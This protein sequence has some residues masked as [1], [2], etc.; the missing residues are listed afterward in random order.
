MIIKIHQSLNT[1]RAFYYNEEKVEKKEAYFFAFANANCANPFMY[2]RS[3]RMN[4]LTQIEDGNTRAKHKCFH[5]SI[6]PAVSDLDR[7]DSSSLKTE[8]HSLMD[9][10]GYGQQPYYVYRHQ[11]I[12]R[13]HYHVVSTRI[14][15]NTR[16]QIKNSND[17]YIIKDFIK[18]LNLKY[19]LETSQGKKAAVNLIASFKSTDLKASIQQV[20]GLLNQI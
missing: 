20:F 4:I 9:K 3:F 13:E 14:D 19:K 1:G 15:V 2:E 6:N 12:K 10:L 8:I 11:D 16:K 18:E 5:L 17:R 7:I